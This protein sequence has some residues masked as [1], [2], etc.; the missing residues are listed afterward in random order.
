M[1]RIRLGNALERL[2]GF[3]S[4]YGIVRR[5]SFDGRMGI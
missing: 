3:G 4:M 1:Y 5:L 2:A